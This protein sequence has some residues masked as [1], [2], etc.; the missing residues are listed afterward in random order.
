MKQYIY[1]PTE[2]GIPQFSDGI[3]RLND[4]IEVTNDPSAADVFI[5]PEPLFKFTKT[6]GLDKIPYISHYPDRHVFFDLSEHFTV[7]SYQSPIFI[8]AALTQQ[9]LARDPNSIAWPWPVDDFSDILC[10]PHQMSHRLSFHG[11]ASS[12]ARKVAAKSCLEVMGQHAD[13]QLYPS[14]YG[15]QSPEQQSHHRQ[16]YKESMQ[17]SQLCLSVESIPGV[18]PYRFYEAMSAGRVQ[19][20]VGANYTLPFADEI[21]YDNFVLKVNTDD[22]DQAGIVARDWIRNAATR[23]IVEKGLEARHYWE[24]YLH[25]DKWVDLIT[26]AVQKKINL[27]FG[28]LESA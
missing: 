12:L 10:Q 28:P 24:K 18:I 9:I 26:Y 2:L 27:L 23:S 1:T 22:A 19:L 25:R 15:Y 21:P 7:Y 20:Y 5:V 17:R 3:L 4:S 8:R 6:C 11:W 13:I 16:L 14:F